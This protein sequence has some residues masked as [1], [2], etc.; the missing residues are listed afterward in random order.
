M[1]GVVASIIIPLVIGLTGYWYN[2]ALKEREI[3]I[4]YVELAASIL[5]DT[6]K[7]SNKELRFWAAR[8]IEHYSPVQLSEGALKELIT[9]NI[10]FGKKEIEKAADEIIRQT[11]EPGTPPLKQQK[12]SDTH[13]EKP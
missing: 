7:E 6:P 9:I 8:V 2:N 3:Q 11:F 4:R 12:D 1:S 5:R 10:Y 13:S